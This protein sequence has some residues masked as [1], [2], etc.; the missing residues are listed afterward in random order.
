MFLKKC[1]VE[2]LKETM[3]LKIRGCIFPFLISQ[4]YVHEVINLLFFNGKDDR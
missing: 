3:K 4:V 2:T 1:Q